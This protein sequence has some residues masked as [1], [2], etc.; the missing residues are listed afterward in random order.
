MGVGGIIFGKWRFDKRLVVV[1]VV[2]F[3]LFVVRSVEIVF[4]FNFR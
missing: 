4:N 3:V 1:G 2:M